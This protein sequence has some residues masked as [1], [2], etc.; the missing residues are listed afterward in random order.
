[1]DQV[2]GDNSM[3]AV[4]TQIVGGGKEGG[5]NF[6]SNWIIEKNGVTGVN[7]IGVYTANN[8]ASWN[9]SANYWAN[10][11]TPPIFIPDGSPVVLEGNYFYDPSSTSLAAMVDGSST[12]S[13]DTM[14]SGSWCGPAI[15][16]VK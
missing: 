7:A 11:D 12:D 3:Q 6:T 15:P 10:A 14:C 4:I 2:I 8:W 16:N 5:L 13:T 9:I 1:M